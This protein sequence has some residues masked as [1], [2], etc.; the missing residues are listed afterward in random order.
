MYI[1]YEKQYFGPGQLVPVEPAPVR[2]NED[3][4][5]SVFF[6]K[7]ASAAVSSVPVH[8]VTM[9]NE[10]GVQLATRFFEHHEAD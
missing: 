7:C 10:F 2:E 8:S 9:E 3:E 4:A 1:I 6:Q 5:W